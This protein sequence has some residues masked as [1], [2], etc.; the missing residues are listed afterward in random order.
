MTEDNKKHYGPQSTSNGRIIAIAVSPSQ[1]TVAVSYR[2]G[3]LTMVPLPEL[4]GLRDAGESLDQLVAKMAQRLGMVG[5]VIDHTATDGVISLAMMIV[6]TINGDD[7]Q[8]TGR[9]PL[10]LIGA[11]A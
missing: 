11:A 3:H 5:Q 8:M 1:W 9:G 6:D 2:D 10:H 7:G 4:L